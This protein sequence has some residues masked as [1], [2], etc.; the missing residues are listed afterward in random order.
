MYTKKSKHKTEFGNDPTDD[1]VEVLEMTAEDKFY[2]SEIDVPEH[3]LAFIAYQDKI[4]KAKNNALKELHNE[5]E[6][7][8]RLSY[9]KGKIWKIL[10]L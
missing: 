5:L 3:A 8:D 9:Y 2:S 4:I 6:V 1:Y 7:N 10:K